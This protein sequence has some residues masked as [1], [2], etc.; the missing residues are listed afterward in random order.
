MTLWCDL[1]PGETIQTGDRIALSLER[2]RV[3]WIYVVDSKL[4]PVTEN[5]I[6]QRPVKED[7]KNGNM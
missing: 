6:A 4:P 3:R 1:Q 7:C 2:G 5:G